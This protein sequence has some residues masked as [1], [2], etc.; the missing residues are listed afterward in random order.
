M[1]HLDIRRI[2]KGTAAT[3]AAG[4]ALVA[5][6]PLG[7]QAALVPSGCTHMTAGPHTGVINV[8]ANQKECLLLAVQN[9]A[10][11]VAPGGAL[12]VEGSTI[13]GAVT[14]IGGF[15]TLEFCNSST[16]RGAIVAT[17]GIGAV[18]IG[19]SGLLGAL[20][21]PANTIDGAVTLDSNQAGVEL[22]FGHVVGAVVA[23]ANLGGTTLSGNQIGGKLTC[24]ANVPPPVN[25]G[26]ANAVAGARFGQTC[27]VLTF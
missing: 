16:V 22:S 19:G 8:A 25:G 13:T 2:A 14:L 24:T 7:A 3:L 26:V 18:R 20:D 11:N 6:A 15:K 17:G 1:N 9:G 23:N 10:V 4:I 21:C 27:S 12:D 5:I